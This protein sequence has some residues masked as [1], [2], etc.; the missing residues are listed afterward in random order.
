LIDAL[1]GKA[2]HYPPS[3]DPNKPAGDGVITATELYMYLRDRVEPDTEARAKRQTPGIFP[4]KKHDKGEYI[5]LSPGHP[6]NLPP[7]PPLDVSSN[8]YRGL[9]SFDEGQKDLFFGRQGLTQTLSEF[10]VAHSLTVVLGSSGSGKSSLVKA[11]LIPKLRQGED[12]HILP[13]LRPGELPFK[14]LNQALAA[15]KPS[16]IELTPV[17]TLADWFEAHPKAHLLIVVDQFEEMITLCLDERERKQFFD[18][19]AGAIARYPKQFHLVLTLRSDFEPQFRKTALEAHW[20]AARFVVPAMT[21]EELRQAI[22]SPASARVMYFEPHDLVDRLIDEVANMPGA[23]PL[24]SFALSE[25]YLNYLQRQKAAKDRGETIDRAIAQAD[26]EKVGGVT[27][28]LTQRAE[29]EYGA[30]V[31]E[32]VAYAQTIRNVMLRM[33]SVGGEMARRQVPSSELNYPQREDA[34]VK[35]VI[36]RFEKARLLT[37]GTDSEDRPYQEPAH[38]ALVRGWTRLL[39]W[40]REHLSAVILQRELTSDATQWQAGNKK[41]QDAGLL[42]IEDPRLPTALQLSCG[43]AYRDTWFN[44]FRW[45]FRYHAW[46]SQPHDYWFNTSE[47]DFVWQSFKHKFT[48]FGQTVMTLAGVILVLS[49]VTVYALQRAKIAQLREQSAKV[50]NLLNTTNAVEGLVLGIDTMSQSESVSEVEMTAQSSLLTA[51]QDSQEVNRLQGHSN[52]VTMVAFSADGQR[53]V[54]ASADNTSRVWDVKTGQELATLKGH[55]SYILT[56]EF[57]A[58]GQR[59][60]TASSDE[61]ARVWDAQTGKELATLKGHKSRVN[62]A[63]FSADGQRIVTTSSDKTAWVWDAK[64]GQELMV[65]KGHKLDVNTAE[66]S[67]DGQRIVTTSGDNTVRVWDAKMGKAIAVLKGYE[68]RLSERGVNTASFSMDNQRI[69]TVSDDN[70]A[71]VWDARTGKLIATLKG[72]IN[73][74]SFSPDGQRIVGDNIDNTVDIWDAT[75]GQPIGPPLKGHEDSV[76]TVTFSL[77]GKR[78]VSGSYDNKVRV[79][80]AVTG[81]PI[82]P[83]LNGYGGGSVAFSP[84]G[85]RVASRSR[86]FNTVQLWNIA[87]GKSLQG[88]DPSVNSVAFSPDSKRIISS[89]GDTVDVWDATTGQLMGPPLGRHESFVSSVAFSPDGKRI[90]SRSYGKIQLWDIVTGKEIGPPLEG[91]EG[92]VNSVAFSPDGKRIVSGGDGKWTDKTIRLW[93]TITG[94]PIGSPLEHKGSI[95]SVSFSPDGKRI[96]S[97]SSDES[98]RLWDAT[99]GQPIGPILKGNKDSANSVAFSPDGKR[100]VSGGNEKIRL[101]DITTGKEIGPPLEGHEGLVNSVAFSPDGKRIISGSSDKTVRLWDATTGQPIGPPLKHR[102]MINTVAFSP[103]GERIISVSGDRRMAI[104]R[105]LIRLWDISPD[106]WLETACNRLQYHPLLNHPETVT[107][108]PEMLKVSRRS[109]DV[110]QRRVW[111]QQPTPAANPIDWLKQTYQ[112]VTDRFF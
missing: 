59:I 42:W 41:N 37:S 52:V 80:D 24:L 20:Q 95:N 64:T 81:Q 8:P 60:V 77:D 32:D 33:V 106:D 99:T 102:D 74:A 67:A 101:W 83:P 27:Q 51:V 68:G 109:K 56:A 11:G 10:V 105:D 73:T 6:L 50:L 62:T 9:E 44:L 48:R 110:C 31:Q 98:V 87:T 76:K 49:G 108:D 112:W 23:L 93:D 104:R 36:D 16:S 70:T 26:Y 54:T 103:D 90:V 57:S 25:L 29:H 47:A 12:W 92:F 19:L 30:L 79:W 69:L 53:I 38:D 18:L 78:I 94:Q 40:R 89:S 58:D 82:G 5:F 46:Q 84:D 45:R 97:G 14:A 15:F 88:H 96:I 7:A 75:T 2:D 107:S 63:K 71:R 22:E 86:S 21:R 111:H 100:I 91:Y 55:E 34:L 28:S 39:N 85:Q 61:T 17:Q 1:E 72:H 35:V 66:F 4:L 65:L 43:K 13:T 3:S